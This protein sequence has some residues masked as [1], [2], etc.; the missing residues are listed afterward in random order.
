MEARLTRYKEKLVKKDKAEDIHPPSLTV[1][2]IVYAGTV[3][4]IEDA[5]LEIKE[6][7]PGKVKFFLNNENKVIYK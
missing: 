5:V 3:I 7:I 6:D 1:S 2:K 4:R